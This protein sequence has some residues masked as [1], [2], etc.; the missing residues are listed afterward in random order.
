MDLLIGTI[1]EGIMMSFV[2]ILSALGLTMIYG[3]LHIINFAHGEIYMLGAIGTYY[4][5][6]Y[7][8]VPYFVSLL[9]VAMVSIPLGMITDKLIFRPLRGKVYQLLV[10]T[11]GLSMVLQSAGWI[12]F[13]ILDKGVPSVFEGVVSFWVIRI[14]KERLF[15]AAVGAILVLILVY[16]VYRTKT[17]R[18]MRA[19]EEDESAAKLQGINPNVVSSLDVSIG[20][21]LASIAGGLMAPVYLVNPGMGT[22]TILFCFI[23][24]IVGGLGSIIGCI[25]GGLFVG[26]IQTVGSV[27]LGI[28]LTTG[29]L[30]SLMIIVLIIRPKGLM[31][32][33]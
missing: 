18:A 24:V 33:A 13:G 1:I 27:Y 21:A 30:F 31:G 23:I 14:S 9:I 10:A 3:I 12:S 6:V 2:Y 7:F 25:L 5:T 19:I 29:L 22:G 4:L 11:L 15:A 8:K 28:Q 32:H 16:F 26:I 20:F 17:G